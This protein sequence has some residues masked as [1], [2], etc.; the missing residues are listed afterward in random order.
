MFSGERPTM[1]ELIGQACR[2]HP[3]A[4]FIAGSEHVTALTGHRLGVRL[5]TF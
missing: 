3:A 1:R 5:G 4:L 2:H